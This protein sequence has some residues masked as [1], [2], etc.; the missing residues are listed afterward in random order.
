MANYVS[1]H[2]GAEI[3]AA[4]DAAIH[5][6]AIY[7]STTYAEIKAAFDAG[8]TV[9]ARKGFQC[10][11][12][13]NL[14]A[15]AISF[16][17]AN[18]GAKT[19]TLLTVTNADVWSENTYNIGDAID[20]IENASAPVI[21]EDASGAVASFSDGAALPLVSC[22]VDV[23]P[24]QAALPVDYYAVKYL[25]SSGT[26]YIDMGYYIAKEK[27]RYKGKFNFTSVA[28]GMRLFG[29]ES[30]SWSGII[31]N[32]GGAVYAGS[33]GG[34]F[35]LGP[36]S[37]DTDYDI[38]LLLDNGDATGI[39]NGGAPKT[40]TYS[41]TLVNNT[42]SLWLF[43]VNANGNP[44]G[45]ISAKVYGFQIY[46]DDVLVRDLIPCVRRSDSEVGM[47]DLVGGTFYT[48]A[49]TGT[50]TAGGL[51]ELPITGTTGATVS[52]GSTNGVADETY[53]ADWSAYG[54][55][56]RG[57]AD[58]VSGA[59]SDKTGYIQLTYDYVSTL[60]EGTYIGM[61]S[62]ISQVGGNAVWIRNWLTPS[63]NN[64]ADRIAGGIYA[65]CNYFP[66]AVNNSSIFAS[67]YRVYM[68]VPASVATV[69]D[70]LAMLQGI[71]TAGGGVYVCYE[72]NTPPDFT[73]AGTEI[74][75]LKGQNY[76]WSDAG[77]V[78]ATY[79]ADTALFVESKVP[80]APAGDGTYT[81]TCT[82][83]G[84]VATYS[85]A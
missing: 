67:Q 42:R 30:P 75:G 74:E 27:V 23:M 8:R 60:A 14:V 62:G 55:V 78:T 58:A 12:L 80:E 79:R 32:L 54:T 85:W 61:A 9:S 10:F 50:F 47:Y 49:G 57:T 3:D 82:V 21:I 5:F 73:F 69:A 34:I 39:V 16:S 63:N 35:S 19:I 24:K 13:A 31:Y 1:T 68:G 45:R 65:L 4:V 36:W 6:E 11:Q 83:S 41:G 59:G 48:N 46:E 51:A 20:A 72:L 17:L 22:V 71:E 44:S 2:T 37:A 28:S 26:Q 81:L 64:A 25:E 40:A 29:R 52:V 76:I 70:F 15:A 18:A 7:G 53:T 66:V 84:G 43:A 33:S 38:D 56:Y 77:D